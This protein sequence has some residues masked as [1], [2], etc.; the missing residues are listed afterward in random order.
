MSRIIKTNL[1][2]LLFLLAFFE[3]LVGQ[4]PIGF[5]VVDDTGVLYTLTPETGVLKTIGDTGTVLNDIAL[6]GE[7]QLFGVTSTH[8]Y[9]VNP[10]TAEIEL[11]GPLGISLASGLEFS[12]DGSLFLSD[13]PT[14]QTGNLYTV[15]TATGAANQIGEIGFASNGDLAFDDIGRLFM[16]ATNFTT[17][18][19]LIEVDPNT[20]AGSLIGPHGYGS[21]P[22]MD[23]DGESLV[24]VNSQGDV[25]EL[26]RDTGAGSLI[27]NTMPKI[28]AAGITY[29]G[30]ILFGDVNCDGA[31]D[32]LD[33]APFIDTL[34]TDPFNAK[35]DINQDGVVDLLDVQ[36]FVDLLTG[37]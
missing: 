27:S 23:F 20:G 21:L 29:F 18:F 32:L 8:L 7:G 15:D 3:P 11:I 33:V 19:D 4:A 31:V 25:I 30:G 9:E 14:P 6:S 5:Y 1:I 12:A 22:A 13:A 36:P 24:G 17:Q 2:S 26:D 28:S 35:A 37:G 16:T 10:S 34:T